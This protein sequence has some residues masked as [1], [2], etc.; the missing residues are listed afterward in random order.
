MNERG[1]VIQG[2]FLVGPSLGIHWPTNVAKSVRYG[3]EAVPLGRE[4]SFCNAGI[5]QRLPTPFLQCAEELLGVSL[6]EVRI[7]QSSRGL[8]MGA[9]AFTRGPQ[10]S[11][12]PGQY[13]PA[14]PHGRRLLVH[15]LTHV[16]QQRSG[17]VRNPF[18]GQ[19]TLVRDSLLEAEAERVATLATNWERGQVLRHSTVQTAAAKHGARRVI[20]QMSGT[21]KIAPGN[22]ESD[23]GNLVNSWDSL[24]KKDGDKNGDKDNQKKK[25]FVQD[26]KTCSICFE[27]I[28]WAAPQP[29][30]HIFHSHCLLQWF[31]NGNRFCPICKRPLPMP[32][33]PLFSNK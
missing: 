13:N 16:V 21:G 27:E 9:L 14:T 20:Q 18:H 4:F 31:T 28:D 8:P 17:R 3:N 24:G 7:H 15:E 6:E 26:T 12:A 32:Y 25:K 11:F 22:L 30:G 5:V 2:F 10:I 19:V 29:C 33:I 1:G 23:F